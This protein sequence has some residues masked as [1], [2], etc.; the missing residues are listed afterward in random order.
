ALT[1]CSRIEPV[2]AREASTAPAHIAAAMKTAAINLPARVISIPLPSDYYALNWTIRALSGLARHLARIPFAQNFC[3]NQERTCA[4]R[5]VGQIVSM[6]PPQSSSSNLRVALRATNH[7]R[8]I[9]TLM[10]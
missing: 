2:S 6:P 4:G 8:P 7:D 1:T 3:R 5:L 10:W 9:E